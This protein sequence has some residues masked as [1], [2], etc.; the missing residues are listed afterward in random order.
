[1]RAREIIVIGRSKR[2]SR[3]PTTNATALAARRTD[4]ST[5]RLFK[6]DFFKVIM[7]DSNQQQQQQQKY[8][9]DMAHALAAQHQHQQNQT[10]LADR[11][12]SMPNP[13]QQAHATMA[14]AFVPQFPFGSGIHGQPV[15]NEHRVNGPPAP[16]GGGGHWKRRDFSRRRLWEFREKVPRDTRFP[17]PM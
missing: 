1:M 12:V 13:A 15:P 3:R 6:L 17:K 16:G 8:A 4:V 11:A 14:N 10:T 5:R 9:L 7:G 2:A